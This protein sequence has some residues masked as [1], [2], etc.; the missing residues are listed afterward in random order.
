MLKKNEW[1]KLI[2]AKREEILEVAE[3]AFRDACDDGRFHNVEIG[4]DGKVYAWDTM[5]GS[6]QTM[7][8]HN[9][10]SRLLMTFDENPLDT[11]EENNDQI[12]ERLT[13]KG[14]D[15]EKLLEDWS[16]FEEEYNLS[17]IDYLEDE[18]GE[19]IREAAREVRNDLEAEYIEWY[20]DEYEN[21]EPYDKLERYL[22]ELEDEYEF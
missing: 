11:Y 15:G 5:D 10:E 4:E 19:E 3:Q 12:A 21:Q 2:E 1:I 7:S 13:K 17:F 9:G 14:Y 22:D 8:S 6:A 16:D 18:C 20:K